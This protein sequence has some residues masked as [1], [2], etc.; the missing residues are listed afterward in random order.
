[1]ARRRLF[2]LII[3]FFL[4]WEDVHVHS[5]PIYGREVLS[6]EMVKKDN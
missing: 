4:K 5:P 3:A 6:E 1:M 2:T